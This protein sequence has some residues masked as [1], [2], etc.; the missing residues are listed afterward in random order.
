MNQSDLTLESFNNGHANDYRATFKTSHGR[1]LY[2]SVELN[3]SI[4]TITDC[5]YIDRNQGKTGIA[6]YG[7]RPKKLCTLTFPTDDLLKV[8]EAEL[9]KHFFDVDFVQSNEAEPSLEE[10]LR[11]KADSEK[12]V[13]WISSTM[14]YAVIS[15]ILS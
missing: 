4:C 9:D 2:L 1:N 3:G 5:F 15:R 8:I 14:K 7:A 13:F 12:R 6:R 10:Y 11:Y